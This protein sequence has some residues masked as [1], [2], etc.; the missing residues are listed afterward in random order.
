MI[1]L[2]THST[3]SDGTLS[4]TELIEEACRL[5]LKALALT[6]HDVVDGLPEFQAAAQKHPDLVAV[7]GCELGVKFK[8]HIEILALNIKNFSP[9]RER[10]EKLLQIRHQTNL[11]R[12]ELLNKAG[13]PIRY[14]DVAFDEKG[15]KRNMVSQPHFAEWL[16]EKGFIQTE[17]EAYTR[18]LG[19]GCP[20]YVKKDDPDLKETIEFIAQ[21][22]AVPVMAHPYLARLESDELFE[23][24]KELKS[25]GLRGIECYH[26]DQTQEQTRLYLNMARD[27][28][29]LVSG[30]SDYHGSAHPDTHMGVGRGN[31]RIPDELL[32][33]I[34]DNRPPSPAFYE[35]LLV[36][37]DRNVKTTS[38]IG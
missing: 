35:E 12:I 14:E 11:K 30:G 2:H 32:E 7:N 22:G 16:L 10:Q 5:G 19:K 37:L 33:F 34:L 21:T 15:Q 8:T 28:G 9:Y 4:P 6:D 26:S 3:S 36:H 1:D 13:V 20:A 29:L 25:Y 23:L 38:G 24:L 27:L 31:L 17:R 18:F